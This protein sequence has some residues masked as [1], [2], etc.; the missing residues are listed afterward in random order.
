MCDIVKLKTFALGEYQTNCYV[1]YKDYK[2]MIIDPGYSSKEIEDFLLNNGIVLESVFITHG[3]FDH[4]GGVNSLKKKYPNITVYA[5]KK[6]AYWY[7][8]DPRN[9]I[10][11]DIMVDKYVTEKDIINFQGVIF[12]IIETPGHTYGSVCLYADKVLFSGDTLFYH[13]V[14]RT[15][16]YL[17]DTKALFESVKNK[18]FA[19]PDDTIVYPGHGRATTIF[20]EKTNNPFVGKEYLWIK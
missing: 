12:K 15:D 13:S 17:G 19:L 5:P 9:K 16:L 2:A 14:G 20:E 11:E 4:V 18:L 10:Y 1:L 8:R 7:M 3:H 6:D